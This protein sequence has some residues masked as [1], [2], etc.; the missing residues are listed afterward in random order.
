MIIKVKPS[1]NNYEIN[2]TN[3]KDKIYTNFRLNDESECMTCTDSCVAQCSWWCEAP[4]C[5]TGCSG[6]CKGACGDGCTSCTGCSGCS[7]CSGSCSGCQG[8][9][10]CGGCDYGCSGSCKNGCYG[11]CLGS[12]GKVGVNGSLKSGKFYTSI[13]NTIK[14]SNIQYISINGVIKQI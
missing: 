14:Q 4:G 12:G 7:S 13:S 9:S 3:H 8:C 5:G 11:L 2:Y 1:F 6:S 10:G